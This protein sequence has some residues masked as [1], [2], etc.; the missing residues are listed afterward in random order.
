MEF[1]NHIPTKEDRDFIVNDGYNHDEDP[2]YDTLFQVK[3]LKN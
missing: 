1:K 3:S 2:T